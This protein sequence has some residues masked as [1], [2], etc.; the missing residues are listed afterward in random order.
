MSATG[1]SVSPSL[2]NKLGD[3]Y[4]GLRLRIKPSNPQ[5]IIRELCPNPDACVLIKLI[6]EI[7]RSPIA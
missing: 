5:L 2:G 6:Y 1:Y 7:V 4:D 3:V